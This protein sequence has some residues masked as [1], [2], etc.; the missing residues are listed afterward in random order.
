MKQKKVSLDLILEIYSKRRD[1][2]ESKLL[3]FKKV[4]SKKD[5]VIFEELAY[6]ILTAK[7]SARAA[8]R[9]I[10]RL[11]EKDLLLRGSSRKVERL[12]SGVLYA[13]KKAERI[14]K[15]RSLFRSRRGFAI[16][17]KLSSDP[18]VAR[19]FLA[20]NV[21]GM[22]YKEASHFLRN[23]GYDGLAI[24]D[25]HVLKGLYELHVISEVPKSLTRKKYLEIE[26]AYITFA[27]S[28][29]IKPEALDL[30]LWSAKTGEM[31][32]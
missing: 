32:K 8:E 11:K 1:E 31:L 4:S 21:E 16:K 18:Y 3:E 15:A 20:D 27:N 7:S 25:R 13:R 26:N 24:L 17:D 28:I 9:A 6:C 10:R 22:G 23:I 5:E 2:I 29:G 12:L 14:V 19:K 30:V